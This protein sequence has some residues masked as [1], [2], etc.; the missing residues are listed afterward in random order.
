[1]TFQSIKRKLL[2]ELNKRIKGKKEAIT[3][4]LEKTLQCLIIV[5]VKIL[6]LKD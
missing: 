5:W 1:M 4:I 2:P 6:L 3:I